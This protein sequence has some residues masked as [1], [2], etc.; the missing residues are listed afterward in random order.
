MSALHAPAADPVAT[1]RSLLALTRPRVI[2]LV[3]F[4][5][6]PA[7][8]RADG[9][10]P[11]AATLAATLAGLA[12]VGM[13]CDALNSWW[14]RDTDALMER[15]RSRPL[16]SGR[17]APGAALA[18]GLACAAAALVALAWGAGALAAAL[19]LATLLN[20]ALLYT[21]V[22]KRRTAQ[23][24]VLGGASGAAAP[25]IAAAAA[26]GRV[27]PLAWALFA[28]VFLWTPPHFWAIA[29][30]RRREYDAAGIP[31]LPSLIGVKRTRRRQ[32]AYSLMLTASAGSLAFLPRPLPAAAAVGVLASLGFLASLV[33]ASRR[34][35]D[36]ADRAAYRTSLRAMAAFGLAVLLET[37][38]S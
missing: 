30:Y 34:E 8:R 19:G 12:L 33:A 17:L 9:T 38:L 15:T 13:A 22:L 32:V 21:A 5:G 37:L 20:Y 11:D 6:L 31:V 7:L 3:V 2:G 27:T 35:N 36:D 29:L 16:P 14:E 25:L 24:V 4:T 1:L 18:F 26:E 23:A 28:F 10:W